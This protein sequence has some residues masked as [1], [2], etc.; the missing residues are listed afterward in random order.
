M[1]ATPGPFADLNGSGTIDSGETEADANRAALRIVSTGGLVSSASFN[2]ND[3][4]ASTPETEACMYLSGAMPV[5]MQPLQMG[6]TLPGGGSAA[7]CMPVTI[8]PQLMYG[9]S[10][11]MTANA[12]ISITTDTKV[13]VLRLREPSGGPITGYIIDD[14]GKPSMIVALD[15]YMDAPDMSILLSSH[16]LH[17]KPLSVTLKGPVTFL[18]D[19]RIAIAAANTADVPITINISTPLGNG[20]VDLVIPANEMKLQLLSKPLRGGAP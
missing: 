7:S 4:I 8:S 20:N 10:L 13:S 18:A 6:C 16:D 12:G 2:G 17:S 3:C 14:G 15:L 11:S 9:T 1:L 5:E 19:G